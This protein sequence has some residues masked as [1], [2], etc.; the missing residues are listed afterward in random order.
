MESGVSLALAGL[1][2]LFGTDNAQVGDL[3]DRYE[4][5]FRMGKSSPRK[6]SA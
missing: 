4:R 1:P 3:V 2:L 6:R 5:T